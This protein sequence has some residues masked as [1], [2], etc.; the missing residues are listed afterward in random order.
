MTKDRQG[1]P[2]LGANAAAGLAFDQGLA[3]YATYHGDP[4]AAFDRAIEESPDC[5]MAWIAKAWLHALATESQASQKART[6]LAKAA[7]LPQGPREKAHCEALAKLL[8]GEWSQAGQRLERHS[9]QMPHDL[10]ALQSGHMIDFFAASGR[11]LRDRIARVLPLWEG[12]PG[13]SWVMG[14]AA[15]GFEEAGDYQQAEA[16]GREALAQ[17]PND[18]WAHHAV[19]HV[20][21]MTGRPEEGLSW[22][23]HRETFWASPDD[24]LQTHNWWHRA[25]CHIETD[26]LQGAMALYDGPIRG[27]G[28]GYTLAL[29]DA[30]ALLWRLDLQGA[31]TGNRWEELSQKWQ[32]Q[33]D[34]GTYAFNDLHEAM[35]HLGADRPDLALKLVQAPARNSEAGLWMARYGKPLIQGFIAFKARD[36]RTAADHLMAARHIAGGFGGSHAQRDVIDWTL[37]EVALRGQMAGLAQALAQERLAL[38]P[39]SPVNQAFLR[40]AVALHG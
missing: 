31:D 21:E 4:I 19:A 12:V 17:D 2:L 29:A 23:A 20:M 18:S 38:R 3:A 32:L 35:A 39:H 15:F 22:M 27:K 40:R 1:N 13:A 30:S 5:A 33:T 24:M 34:P 11:S 9:A 28:H 26:D 8:Q 36:Y 16:L 14:M 25:L 10:L 6:Y 7:T 37:A